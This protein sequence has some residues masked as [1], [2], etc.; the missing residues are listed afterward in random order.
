MGVAWFSGAAI[1]L[2]VAI[3]FWEH[4][5]QRH[6]VIRSVLSML[7]DRTLNVYGMRSGVAPW[8]ETAVKTLITVR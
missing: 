1:L 5:K 8:A 2:V 4:T 6:W 3:W 7:A